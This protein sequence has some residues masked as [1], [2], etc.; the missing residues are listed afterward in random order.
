M[1]GF[2]KYIYNHKPFWINSLLYNRTFNFKEVP[3]Q[4]DNNILFQMQ[5]FFF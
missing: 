1:I 2:I 3:Y 4:E 5:I